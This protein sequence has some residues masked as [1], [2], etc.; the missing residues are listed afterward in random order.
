MTAKNDIEFENSV[1]QIARSL[2]SDAFYDG[3]SND[4]GRERDGKFE[5]RDAIY[6]VEATTSRQRDKIREDAKKTSQLVQRLRDVTFKN[7]HGWLVT[8]HEPTADQREAAKPFSHSIKILGFDQFRSLLFNGHEY[9]RCRDKYRF[10]SI[11]DFRF[12]AAVPESEYVTVDFVT[13]DRLSQLTFSEVFKN[14]HSH[15]GRYVITGEYG[16]GKSMS[17][18]ALYCAMRDRYKTDHNFRCP[19][20]LNLRDHTGQYSPVEALERHARNVGYPS[21]TDL[22]RAWRAGYVDL[23]LDGFDEMATAGWGGVP[24][25]GARPPLFR[26]DACPLVRRR[27]A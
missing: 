27:I 22:V 9:I 24:T 14:T 21:S 15:A 23:L 25:K 6:I 10:G 19:I 13:I 8:K 26:Y 16:S 18:R 7:V 2:W 20:Y 17:L 3:A 4:E 12:S 5:T 11:H 1:R